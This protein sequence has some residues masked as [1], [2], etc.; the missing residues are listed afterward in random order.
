MSNRHIIY[1][2][3]YS[4]SDAGI[5]TF[6]NGVL[7]LLINKQII[8]VFD[9]ASRMSFLGLIFAKRKEHLVISFH[10]I[11][12][13]TLL[14]T[15]ILNRFF[16]NRILIFTHGMLEPWPLTKRSRLKLT[17][18][19]IIEFLGTKNVTF[20]GIS[21]DEV[22]N[23]KLLVRYLDVE[24]LSPFVES[25]NVIP[26]PKRDWKKIIYIGRFHE[27]K[28]LKEL[29]SAFEMLKKEDLDLNLDIFGFG[30][31]EFTE[32]LKL[33][34][35]LLNRVKIN[36]GIFGSEKW[37]TLAKSGA[38]I[39]PSKSE[40]FGYV[41]PEAMSQGCIILTTP[42]TPWPV[43]I[44]SDA[45]IL[46]DDVNA[47]S[48]YKSLKKYYCLKNETLKILEYSS[49]LKKIFQERFSEEAVSQNYLKLFK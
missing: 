28:G 43:E 4:I 41:I 39:L 5:F 36:E 14:V 20:V 1:T 45:M 15:L 10:C 21:V 2:R 27:K 38:M 42:N 46:I 35:N 18:L 25:E 13:V 12:S 23:T 29:I 6:I 49:Q 40:N 17:V 33:S 19:R 22:K 48:I 9:R 34:A 26:E 11:W 16:R 30:S 7:K 44:S 31:F 47:D 3:E 32:E 37:R 8:E 24:Y